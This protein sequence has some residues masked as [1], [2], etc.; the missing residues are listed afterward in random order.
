MRGRRPGPL[1]DGT[2]SVW[3]IFLPQVDLFVNNEAGCRFYRASYLEVLSIILIIREV[4][5]KCLV[6]GKE[7][8]V[9]R[10]A[11]V[12]YDVA[13]GGEVPEPFTVLE[14][15]VGLSL[16]EYDTDIF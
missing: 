15:V 6:A 16:P 8:L 9:R 11:A 10:A 5:F 7:S 13:F 12:K 3:I 4:V 2:K 1:D 14:Y